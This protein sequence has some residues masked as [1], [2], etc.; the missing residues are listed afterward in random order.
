MNEIIQLKITLQGTK[1]LIWRRVLVENSISFFKLHYII[2]YAMGWENRHLFE[3]N[4]NGLRIGEPHEDDE[5]WGGQLID[6]LTVT[7]SSLIKNTKE[8]FTYT[9][10]FGDDWVHIIKVEKFLSK[11]ENVNYSLCI[12]GELNCPPEDCGGVYGFYD[13]IDKIKNKKHPEYKELISWL[14]DNYDHE[15]FDI[16]LV[17]KG[18]QLLNG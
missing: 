2:Q 16:E 13:L 18:L 10:D 9:Y 1:P 7:L 5:G 11:D 4:I 6:S 8:K 14:G 3:F 15:R 17:N 12:D